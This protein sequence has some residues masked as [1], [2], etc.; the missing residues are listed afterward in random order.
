MQ[1]NMQ[2]EMHMSGDVA[3]IAVVGSL[4]STT[5]PDLRDY[6]DRLAP[7]RGPV[8]LDLS[9][10]SCLSSAGLRVLLV[11]CRRAERNGD[12]LTLAGVPAE[13]RGVMAATGFLEFFAIADTVAAGVQE[14]A[15]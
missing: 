15:A 7:G 1:R 14:M 10:M 4:D 13:V 2:L 11:M 5:A 9:R 6:L 3:V 8:L 12:R